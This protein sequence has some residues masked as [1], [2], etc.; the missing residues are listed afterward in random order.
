MKP[1]AAGWS[2]EWMAGYA[3]NTQIGVGWKSRLLAALDPGRGMDS[4]GLVAASNAAL[5]GCAGGRS[6]PW[7]VRPQSGEVGEGLAGRQCCVQRRP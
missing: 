1:K 3:L 2:V 7:S 6:W 4:A 5:L